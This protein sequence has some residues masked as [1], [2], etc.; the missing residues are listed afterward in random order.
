[1][2]PSQLNLGPITATLVVGADGEHVGQDGTSRSLG[3]PFDFEWFVSVRRRAEVILTSGRTYLDEAYVVPA[4]AKLAVFSRRLREADLAPGVIHI[5]ERQASTF[6]D[7]VN[8]LLSLGFERI[9]CEFGPTGFLGLTSESMVEAY[10]S[11]ET[12]G[13][14]ER[15]TAKHGVEFEV[16]SSHGLFIARIGSVAVH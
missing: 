13:G 1:L 7:A 5:S 10:L 9:H 16:V 6:R 8:H 3:G 11:S 15:F 4:N 2:I 14:I 12:I